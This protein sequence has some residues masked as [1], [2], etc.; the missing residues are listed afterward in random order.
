MEKELERV[1]VHIHVCVHV[2]AREKEFPFS[3]SDVKTW[4]EAPPVI[5]HWDSPDPD[6]SCAQRCSCYVYPRSQPLEATSAGSLHVTNSVAHWRRIMEARGNLC[7]FPVREKR[8]EAGEER[9][10]QSSA[11]G[12]VGGLCCPQEHRSCITN[13]SEHP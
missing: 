6:S 11:T 7:H 12:E 5:L 9:L 13:G 2:C 1:C 4:Q 3:V 10:E 8:E